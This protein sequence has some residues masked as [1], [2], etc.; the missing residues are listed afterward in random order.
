MQLMSG[1]KSLDKMSAAL[2][3][4]K[5]T[6]FDWRYKILRSL[7]Q[8]EGGSFFGIAESNETLFDKSDKGSRHLKRKPRKRGGETKGKGISK[9]MA[10]VLVTADRKNGL[11][12]TFCGYGRLTKAKIAESLHT[13]LP[14]GTVL[15][16]DGHVNYKGH[17]M[18]NHIEHVV[19]RA[20]LGRHVKRGFFHI[21]HVN[22][23][24]NRL[25]MD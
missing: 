14:Q 13:L 22:S 25:K 2:H 12:M 4:N 19:F 7:K 5:K 10:T 1:Q 17:A 8:D 9:D 6:A 23:L 20:D 18:D 11:N 15:W 21:Q 3:I 16:A 24:H